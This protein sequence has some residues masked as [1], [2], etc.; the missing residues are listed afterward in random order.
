MSKRMLYWKREFSSEQRQELAESGDAMPDGSFPIVTKSDL[1]NAISAFGRAGNKAAVARHI[2]RRAAALDATDL[3]P[4]EGQLAKLE[5][6]GG[7]LQQG[8]KRRMIKYTITELSGVD[9]PAQEGARAMI[10]KSVHRD[11]DHP[12]GR[13]RK[14]RKRKQGSGHDLENEDDDDLFKAGESGAE[15]EGDMPA[16][17]DK[18]AALEKKAAR[19]EKLAELTDV[20]KT[21]FADLN[22]KGQDAFLAKNADA[23]QADVDAVLEKKNDAD[24]VLYTCDDG[25]PIRK[26]D[27]EL[28]AKL[29]KENDTNRKDLAK[30]QAVAANAEF[31]KSAAEHLGGLPGNIQVRTA[32][33]KAIDGIR[34]ESIRE[35]AAQSVIAGSKAMTAA[36]NSVGSGGGGIEKGDADVELNKLTKAYM[37]KEK[38]DYYTAYGAVTEQNAELHKRAIT[39]EN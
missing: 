17:K 16:D 9:K 29:A 22:E 28:F 26:S 35:L 23:R 24:P 38:V 36:F 37:V 13:E 6:A 5:K 20:Q 25:T 21:H 15:K 27:G 10:I 34:D 12:T 32:I 31:E 2:K 19:F 18:L 1:R 3:L 11:E 33:V 4:E 8:K 39:G 14:R 30:A 7:K